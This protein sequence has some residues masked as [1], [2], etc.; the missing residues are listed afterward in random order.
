MI[1]DIIDEIEKEIRAI[2]NKYYSLTKAKRTPEK[3]CEMSTG[4]SDKMKEFYA[5]I[6]RELK[7]E[8]NP[9]SDLLMSKAW[10]KGHACGLHEVYLEAEDM[11]DLIR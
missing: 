11:V 7:I 1:Y 6:K 3:Y 10:E 5:A 8:D 4:R 9:K 2:E